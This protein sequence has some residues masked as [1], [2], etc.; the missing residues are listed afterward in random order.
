[1]LAAILEALFAV[2]SVAALA[3]IGVQIA[4]V[5]QL[6][7]ASAVDTAFVRKLLESNARLRREVRDLRGD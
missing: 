6:V 4:R 3:Y 7:Q 2:A 5:R 1:M